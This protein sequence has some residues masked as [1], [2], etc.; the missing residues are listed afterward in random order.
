MAK[1]KGQGK[2]RNPYCCTICGLDLPKSS[3]EWGLSWSE[4]TG[5]CKPCLIGI[6]SKFPRKRN[7]KDDLPRITE[8]H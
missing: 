4:D 6:R 3:S 5:V 8:D 1:A 2:V 7:K